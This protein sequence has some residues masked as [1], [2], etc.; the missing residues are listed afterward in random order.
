VL[1]WYWPAT[2]AEHAVAPVS[3]VYWPALQGVQIVEELEAAYLP[4]RHVAH[5]SPV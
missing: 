1:A 5:A 3:K 2:Q 4:G